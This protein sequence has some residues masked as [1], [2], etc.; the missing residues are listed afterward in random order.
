MERKISES[1]IRA[2]TE[3]IKRLKEEL[4]DNQKISHQNNITDFTTFHHPQPDYMNDRYLS[5]NVAESKPSG[6]FLWNEVINFFFP[7]NS[8]TFSLNNPHFHTKIL[9]V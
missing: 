8:S 6:L 3:E 9:H 5:N 2:Q 4:G 1:E 7:S